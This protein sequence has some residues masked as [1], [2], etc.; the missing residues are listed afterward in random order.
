MSL[1]IITFNTF[2][3]TLLQR[4]LI[5]HVAKKKCFQSTFS[6]HNYYFS[7][8]NYNN[9]SPVIAFITMN[10]KTRK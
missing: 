3:V 7:F 8:H 2:A 9:Y 10:T 1:V 5:C 6:F 4:I